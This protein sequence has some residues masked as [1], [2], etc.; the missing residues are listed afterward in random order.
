MSNGITVDEGGRVQC[1]D[2]VGAGYVPIA[3]DVSINGWLVNGLTGGPYYTQDANA[4]ATDVLING[5]RHTAN[6]V[7]YFDTAVKPNTWPEGFATGDDGRQGVIDGNGTSF[8]R[9]IGRTSDGR[10]SVALGEG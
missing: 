3:T 7:R 10:M 9:G 2:A 1:E 5:I 6:G 8:I 4:G